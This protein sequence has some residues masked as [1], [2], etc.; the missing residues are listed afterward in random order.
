MGRRIV[1]T[2]ATGNVGS[3]VVRALLGDGEIDEVIAIARRR[4]ERVPAGVRFVAADVARDDLAPAF[5]GADAVIHLAWLIQPGRDESITRAVNVDGSQRVFEA[6]VAAR[7][8]AVI[9]ASSVGAYSPGP[10]DR[11]VDESWPTAGIASSFYSRHKVAVERALDR[12]EADQP[13]LRVARLRPGLIFQRGA[14][15]EIRRL[16][17]GPLLPGA[18]MRA[19]LAPIVPDVPRLRIQAVHADDV[20]DAY[21]RAVLADVRGAFNVAADPVI[22]PEVLAA[23]VSAR[24]VPVPAR[25]LRGAAAAAYEARLSPTEPGWLDLALGVPLMSTA[26]ARAE[27]GWSPGV[28]ATEALRELADG[29][30]DGADDD[31]PP[32]ARSASGIGRVNELLSG[33]GRRP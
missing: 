15:T 28:S 2:G 20:A 11:R 7:V 8:P 3:A 29:I 31:T 23:M 13:Q 24:R 10:K 6:A 16:F 22:D 26:R 12:L 33:L 14:A 17:A 32:L 9:H 4:P 1:V 21:R 25:L 30:R 27:L 18:V 19:A 5:A